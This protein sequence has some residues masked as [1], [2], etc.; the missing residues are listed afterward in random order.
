MYEIN[1]DNDGIVDW[2][3]IEDKNGNKFYPVSGRFYKT[4][5]LV[6]INGKEVAIDPKT[7]TFEMNIPI[8]KD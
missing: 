4:P 1:I 6:K 7:N 8:K 2:N 5:D 3:I